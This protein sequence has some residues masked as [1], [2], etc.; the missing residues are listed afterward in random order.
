MVKEN[1]KF[2]YAIVTLLLKIPSIASWDQEP[3]CNDQATR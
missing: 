3:S 1:L 2:G